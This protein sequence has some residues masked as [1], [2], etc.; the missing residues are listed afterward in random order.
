VKTLV[1]FEVHGNRE[2]AFVRERQ[3]KN[4]NRAWKIRLIQ[5]MNPEWRDLADDVQP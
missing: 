1:G 2:A 5:R 4:W 3:I